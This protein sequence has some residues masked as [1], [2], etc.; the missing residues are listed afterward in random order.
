MC[1]NVENSQHLCQ[2]QVK[3]LGIPILCTKKD[4][5]FWEFPCLLYPASRPQKCLIFLEFPMK[6]MG[7]IFGIPVSSLRDVHLISEIAQCVSSACTAS[8]AFTRDQSHHL[9]GQAVVVFFFYLFIFFGLF[10]FLM[11]QSE[12]LWWCNVPNSQST[13]LLPALTNNLV[14]GTSEPLTHTSQLRIQ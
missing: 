14:L 9:F 3:D 11:T 8:R 5:H 10:C 1:K 12:V 6:N 2:K 7:K 4:Q 13:E